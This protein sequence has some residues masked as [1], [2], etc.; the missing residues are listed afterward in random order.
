MGCTLYIRCALSIEKYG[1]FQCMLEGTDAIT[2]EVLEPITFVLAYPTVLSLYP[3]LS[4]VFQIP[5]NCARPFLIKISFAVTYSQQGR[6][7]KPLQYTHHRLPSPWSALCDI[8][9][10]HSYDSVTVQLSKG[11]DSLQTV[12]V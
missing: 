9:P 8:S 11:V 6:L 12:A 3:G 7:S 4:Y 5:P 1:I 10:S 2:N